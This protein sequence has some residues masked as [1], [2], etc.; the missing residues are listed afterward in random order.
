MNKKKLSVVMAGAMLASS[1]AP[2]LA[3]TESETDSSQ[4]GSLVVK[5]YDKLTIGEKFDKSE[6]TTVALATGSAIND[7]ANTIAEKSIYYVKITK[8]DGSDTKATEIK[9][10]NA[11]KTG[12]EAE[13]KDALQE[14]FKTLV[15]GDKVEIY[16]VGSRKNDEGKIVSKEAA[17][18]A[19]YTLAEFTASDGATIKNDIA[20]KLGTGSNNK[21]I[22]SADSIDVKEVKDGKITITLESGVKLDKMPAGYEV[23]ESGTKPKLILKVNDDKLDFT[24]FLNADGEPV[25][26][27][28]S[29]PANSNLVHGF[30]KAD[31]T[32]AGDIDGKLDETIKITGKEYTYKTSDLYDGLM[33]TTEGHDLLALVKEAR[34][35]KNANVKATIK[36]VEGSPYAEK[37]NIDN[38]KKDSEGNYV[39]LLEITDSFGVTT[40]YTIKGEQKETETLASWLNKELARVDILAGTNRY[41]TA[42]QIAKEQLGLRNLTSQSTGTDANLNNIVLVNGESLVDGLAAAPLAAQLKAGK[43]GTDANIAAPVLLTEA[44]KLPTA[45][46]EYIKEL[47][48][49]KQIGDV[50]TT[51]HLVGGTT[52]LSRSLERELKSY[53]F[54]IVRY[55][56]DNREETSLKVADKILELQDTDNTGA[57][58]TANRFVVGANG[59]AD[60]MSIAPIAADVNQGGGKVTPIIV[61][62]NGGISEDALET[63]ADKTVTVVG[64][65]KSVS[66]EEYEAIKDITDEKGAI[67]RIAGENRQATNAAIIKTYYK[68]SGINKVDAVLVSKDG[69]GSKDNKELVDALTAAN[70]AVQKN[71]PIVLAKDSLSAEQMDA[72]NLRAKSAEALYQ[73]GIGVSKDNV[74]A[75]IA[76]ALGLSN[77]K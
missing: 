23:D 63:L 51:I 62:K 71:A 59:E 54:K 12:K 6:G 43:T 72:L 70:L 66:A 25:E 37:V 33:L 42:V 46:K 74:I 13:L 39:F 48:A 24:K 69:R 47:L 49:N 1:V 32:P 20:G 68:T 41:A 34:N 15:A 22:A 19:S 77:L 38:L 52:V 3:A 30:P 44:D 14:A 76:K 5:V 4:L 55:N 21:I 50:E 11:T 18:Y 29:I 73:I 45:T 60:A 7:S 56:G 53:G 75:P 28:G 9:I 10:Y 36:N 16:T 65:E 40:L 8:A 26:I 67:R 64:G 2:V 57:N 61:A 27:E 31:P 17:K 35:S 58:E